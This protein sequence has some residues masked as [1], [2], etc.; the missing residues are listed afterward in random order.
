MYQGIQLKKRDWA[1]P[2][3]ALKRNTPQRQSAMTANGASTAAGTPISPGLSMNDLRILYSSGRKASPD[4]GPAPQESSAPAVT[5]VNQPPVQERR[6][7][8]ARRREPSTPVVQGKFVG[9]G[10]TG[11]EQ[12]LR[13]YA[14]KFPDSTFS[15]FF[16]VLDA[17]PDTIRIKL[18][19]TVSSYDPGEK[20]LYLRPS[21]F[22]ALNAALFPTGDSTENPSVVSSLL[23]NLCHEL[24]HA[25]D[26]LGDGTEP[27]REALTDGVMSDETFIRTEFHAWTRE[28]MSILEVNKSYGLNYNDSNTELIE[29][30]KTLKPDMLDDLSGNRT[31]E[32]IK[33]FIRYLVRRKGYNELREVQEWINDSTRKE[34]FRG[35]LTRLQ[36]SVMGKIEKLWPQ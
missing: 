35:Q 24:T 23:S 3:P 16:H 8:H 17:H 5:T 30:W 31:N 13:N 6:G 14:E 27:P 32:I 10:V 19:G 28:A 29:G 11:I 1:D 15:A 21:I 20:R 34:R 33:R 2:S 7:G 12:L 4:A 9:E 36:A 22:P 26:F 18:E 25:Y